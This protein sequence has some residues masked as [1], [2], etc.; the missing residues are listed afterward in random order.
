MGDQAEVYYIDEA[1]NRIGVN[2]YTMQLI[3]NYTRDW[4][5]AITVPESTVDV[6]V[7]GKATLQAE[8]YP[9]GWFY[10]TD[11]ADQ[12]NPEQPDIEPGDIVTASAAGYTNAVNPVGEIDS[13]VDVEAD[14]VTGTLHAPWF[15]EGLRVRCNTDNATFFI[16]EV[17]PDGGEFVCDFSSVDDLKAGG[18]VRLDYYEPGG[19]RVRKVIDIPYVARQYGLGLGRRTVWRRRD[20]G[21]YRHG[22]AGQCERRRYSN[23][24]NKSMGWGM[25]RRKKG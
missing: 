15:S 6:E 18:I 8:S 9:D 16:E 1:G 4:V 24:W 5:N 12:W 2:L 25:V 3:V 11:W 20:D 21:L 13:V 14:I 22:W 23:G 19:N 17:N 7:E 10:S